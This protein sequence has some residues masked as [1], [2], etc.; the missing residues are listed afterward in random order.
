MDC[1]GQDLEDYLQY[2]RVD[3]GLT[4]G[5]ELAIPAGRRL[6]IVPTI[7]FTEGLIEIARDDASNVKNRVITV[8]VALRFRR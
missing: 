2:R 8:G 5:G 3:A 6:L 7:R 4:I 1:D